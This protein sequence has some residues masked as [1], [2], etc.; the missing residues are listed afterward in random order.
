MNLLLQMLKR[1]L[2]WEEQCI[3]I[4][5]DEGV[6][7][8]DYY[9]IMLMF[10]LLFQPYFLCSELLGFELFLELSLLNYTHGWFNGFHSW[11]Q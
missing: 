6:E 10:S 4:K 3:R 2:S 1:I 11:A 5:N 9:G 8:D 7:S